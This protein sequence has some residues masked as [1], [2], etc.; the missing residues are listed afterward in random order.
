MPDALL[1]PQLSEIFLHKLCEQQHSPGLYVVATP[2]GNIF[3][4]TIRAL[5]I[6]K[7]AKC[8]F[9][10]DTRLSKKLLNFYDI[11]TQLIACHEHNEDKIVSFIQ[12]NNIYALI[13]DA[14]TPLI[15][16]PGYKLLN[17]CVGNDINIFPIPGACSV[18]A[19]LSASGLPTNCFTF[20]GFLPK[21]LNAQ[22]RYLSDIKFAKETMIFFESPKRLLSTLSNMLDIF[23]DRFCCIC[24]ELTKVFEELRRCALSDSV[25]HFSINKPIGEFVLIVSGAKESHI[26][27]NEIF[28]HLCKLLKTNSL[29]NS[30]E[31]V[32][33]RYCISKNIIYKKAIEIKKE[34]S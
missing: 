14:G 8:I 12:K 18:I 2:I 29:K 13:S 24:R 27:Q 6:L 15:S 22:K 10:E 1:L 11:K 30:V 21:K 3:D 5:H 19:G 7:N 26:N 23:G 32:S 25:K 9:A 16:D 17:W 4:I 31:E 20:H 33:T 34:K 28:S